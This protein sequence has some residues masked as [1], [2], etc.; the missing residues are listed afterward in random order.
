MSEISDHDITT[1]R[2]LKLNIMNAYVPKY[3]WCISSEAIDVFVNSKIHE[4]SFLLKADKI[5]QL[6][7]N[8]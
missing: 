5:K 1:S 3:L 4:I 2:H 7:S 6:I 8:N